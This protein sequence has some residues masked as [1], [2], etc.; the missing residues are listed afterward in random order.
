[1]VD[2]L[3]NTVGRL[4]KRIAELE[5]R[6]GGGGGGK[7]ASQTEGVRMILMGPPGAGEYL[8]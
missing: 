8:V 1:M 3:K 5:Q 4:E 6:L 7:T 2:D